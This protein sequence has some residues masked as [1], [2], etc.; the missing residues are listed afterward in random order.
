MSDWLRNEFV[1]NSHDVGERHLYYLNK[2]YRADY[3]WDA[4]STKKNGSLSPARR[5]A[6]REGDP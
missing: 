2:M 4:V 1:L 6:Q 3:D 5:S